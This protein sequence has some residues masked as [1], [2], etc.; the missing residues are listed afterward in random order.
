MNTATVR[1]ESNDSRICNI[2]TVVQELSAAMCENKTI[3]LHTNGEGPCANSLGLFDLLN[4]LCARFDYPKN[5]I[6]LRTCNLLES[7]TDYRISVR[8]QTFYLTEAKKYQVPDHTKVFDSD[9]RHF[10]N[11]IGHGN[12]HRLYL[13]SQLYAKHKDHCWQTYHCDTLV[14]YHRQHI[15]IEDIM[16]VTRNK[17][18]IDAAVNL[19]AHSPIMI[20]TIEQYPILNPATLNI[21]K[22]YP[23]FFVELV[24]LSYFSGQTFYLDEKIWRPILMQT[25]FIVQGP[26]HFI[27]NLQRLGFKT[28]DSWWPEGY[29]QDP[30]DSQVD[31]ILPVIEQISKMT[32]LDLEHV[33]QEMQPVLEHN[34]QRFQQLTEVDFAKAFNV[35]P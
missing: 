4:T 28:F 10:G 22:I 33:Y 31:S 24:N 16:Y 15:G 5:K 18:V 27:T 17:T 32:L 12:R 6:T 3:I 21:T 8:P 19:I 2:V 11:F 25:P 26:Q 30:A 20:D 34:Y 29:S 23:K 14:D 7:H 1:V 13:A 35:A 9:F